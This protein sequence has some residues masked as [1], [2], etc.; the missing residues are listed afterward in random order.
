MFIRRL[1]QLA[2]SIAVFRQDTPLN[3]L[4]FL[5]RKHNS[6]HGGTGSTFLEVLAEVPDTVNAWKAH[7]LARNLKYDS[8]PRTRETCYAESNFFVKKLHEGLFSNQDA[9]EKA[10]AHHAAL[11][12]LG[13]FDELCAVLAKRVE[14]SASYIDNSIIFGTA[15]ALLNM[16]LFFVRSEA[17]DFL[18]KH[19]FIAGMLPFLL[20]VGTSMEPA[21]PAILGHGAD[22]ICWLKCPMGKSVLHAQ[23][24]TPREKTEEGDRKSKNDDSNDTSSKENKAVEYCL[25]SPRSSRLRLKTTRVR[26]FFDDLLCCVT[27]V[28]KDIPEEHLSNLAVQDAILPRTFFC[29]KK[30]LP[31]GRKGAQVLCLKHEDSSRTR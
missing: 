13:S 27:S 28:L 25:P 29:W 10:R 26:L 1:L 11:L 3:V 9:W 16:F 22:V 24:G 5:K 23:A 14:F 15:H 31:R 18:I 21:P 6:F 4:R 2:S 20:C 7:M 17:P 30:K 19:A 12:K 8:F